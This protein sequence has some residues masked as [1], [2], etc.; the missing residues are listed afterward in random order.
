MILESQEHRR[1]RSNSQSQVCASS[2]F[3]GLPT[4]KSTLATERSKPPRRNPAEYYVT[5]VSLNDTFSSK[6]IH[7]PFYPDTCKLGR[8]TGAKVKPNSTNGYFDSRVL[9][10]NHA[11]MF[12][13]P[14]NGKLYIQDMGSSNGTFVNLEKISAE[15]VQIQVGDTINL[16]FNIQVETNHKQISARVDAVNVIS[17]TPKSGV[18]TALPGLTQTIIDS[19]SDGDMKHYEFMLKF[20]SQV[21]GEDKPNGSSTASPVDES[22]DTNTPPNA[23]A[24]IENA[25]FADLIPTMESTLYRLAPSGAGFFDNSNIVYS[26]E[27]Q[28]SLDHLTLNIM[29]IKQQNIA[30]KSLETVLINYSAKVT[31]FNSKF[32]QREMDKTVRAAEQTEKTLQAEAA[33]SAKLLQESERKVRDQQRLVTLLREEATRL[34]AEKEEL[35]SQK[36]LEVQKKVDL[37]LSPQPSPPVPTPENHNVDINEPE[38]QED[39]VLDLRDSKLEELIEDLNQSSPVVENVVESEPLVPCSRASSSEQSEQ[40]EQVE[41]AEQEPT[42]EI[43]IRGKPSSKLFFHPALVSFATAAVVAGLANHFYNK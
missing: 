15:P 6:Y 28:T 25:M 10:R 12:V 30:L 36:D 34:R 27:L 5:L 24:V 26:S 41:Q 9:S 39:N 11:C 19:F 40:V 2:M 20:L 31:E 29:K 37:L 3:S 32:L 1:R 8:P 43:P 21:F 33:R 18:L 16:G 23:N 13:D 22:L 17:N 42:T 38:L 7:V 14:H 35:K 4:A